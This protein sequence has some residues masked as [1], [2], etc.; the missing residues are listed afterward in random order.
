M[1]TEFDP[2]DKLLERGIGACALSVTR[3]LR[4]SETAKI[5]FIP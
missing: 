3:S 5:V 1:S 2:P 4:L